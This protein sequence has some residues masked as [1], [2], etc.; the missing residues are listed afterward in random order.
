MVRWPF[1]LFLRLGDAMATRPGRWSLDN[2]TRMVYDVLLGLGIPEAPLRDALVFDRLAT[3]NTGYLP[4]FLQGD[5]SALKQAARIWR[6]AHPEHRHPRCAL[7][8]DGRR[9]FTAVWTRK[10]PVTERG[11]VTVAEL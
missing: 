3:D 10:H 6:E 8:A 1:Q 4:P 9:L 11:E 5:A 2:L 7:S